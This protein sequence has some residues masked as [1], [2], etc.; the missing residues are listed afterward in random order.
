MI[1]NLQIS[2]D[3]NRNAFATSFRVLVK[4]T[5]CCMRGPYILGRANIK[6]M[7]SGNTA[8]FE[9]ICISFT[10]WVGLEINYRSIA[11]KSQGVVGII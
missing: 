9:N 8:T 6:G 4:W 10:E 3:G 5:P 2:W 11:F 1:K 7:S